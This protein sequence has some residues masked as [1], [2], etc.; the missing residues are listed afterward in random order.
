MLVGSAYLDQY[1][2]LVLHMMRC[3]LTADQGPAS[4]T[5]ATKPKHLPNVERVVTVPRRF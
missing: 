1:H 5:Q 4:V 2:E 3:V